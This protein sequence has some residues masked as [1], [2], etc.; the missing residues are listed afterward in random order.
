MELDYALGRLEVPLTE[1][2]YLRRLHTFHD[3]AE[4]ELYYAR[5]FNA[6]ARC[7]GT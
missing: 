1:S 3:I 6:N 4:A 2:E 5:A 7:T